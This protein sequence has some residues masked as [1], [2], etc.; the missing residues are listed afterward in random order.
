MESNSKVCLTT[1][2]YGVKYQRYIPLLLY[3]CYKA[4]PQYDVI[5]FLYD[6]LDTKI[7]EIINNL[8][9]DNRVVIKENHFSDCPDISPIKSK[10]FRW[11]I[12]D[13]LFDD[14]DYL[15]TVDIDM[16]YIKEPV[17]MHIQH[18]RHMKFLGLPISNIQRQVSYNPFSVKNIY[19]RLKVAGLRYFMSF[20]RNNKT[21]IR[22]TGLHFVERKSYYR[23]LTKEKREYF[24]EEIYSGKIFSHIMIQSDEVYLTSILERIGLDHNKLGKQENPIN[25]LDFSNPERYEFR[26]HHGL[27]LGIF[28][29]DIESLPKNSRDILESDAYQYYV[30]FFKENILNDSTF[31]YIYQSS[32]SDIRIY[33]D[34]LIQYYNIDTNRP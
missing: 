3:S 10:A 18:I 25:M 33:F 21:Q 13:D 34:R 29:S 4:Y 12:W 9:L 2:I 16:F 24:K 20:L 32:D 15:Y 28:R 14:Y 26:P 11:I 27:H 7:A 19:R 17:P 23:L 1:Y 22:T 31:E 6:N 8:N 5:L 30:K